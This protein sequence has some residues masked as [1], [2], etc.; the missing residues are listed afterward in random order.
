M[1]QKMRNI[2]PEDLRKESN[3]EP[4]IE[5]NSFDNNKMKTRGTI[6][7]IIKE[8]GFGFIKYDDDKEIFFHFNEVNDKNLISLGANV[9]FEIGI[10][11]R[12]NKSEAKKVT[13]INIESK[14]GMNEPQNNSNNIT[15]I[16]LYPKDTYDIIKNFKSENFSL[17]YNKFIHCEIE[18]GKKIKFSIK[19]KEKDI[20]HFVFSKVSLENILNVQEKAVKSLFGETN[21]KTLKLEIDWRLIVGLGTESVY[22]T[23]MTLHPIYGI[24]YIPGQSIKGIVRSW[25]INEYFNSKEEN[26]LINSEAFCKIFGCPKEIKTEEIIKKTFLK[27]DYQGSMIF[28]DAFPLD[29]KSENLKMDIMNPHYAPYYSE[30]HPPADYYNP[31]PI[32]FMTLE[33]TSFK[34]FIGVKNGKNEVINEK[35]FGNDNLLNITFRFLKEAL[36]NQGIG[37]KTAVGYGFFKE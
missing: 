37:A 26:A 15:P 3:L 16:D 30:G 5:N 18:N 7:N 11:T 25:I 10:N 20:T 28:F 22:E 6:K 13:V 35:E 23:S 9:E 2:S 34:F 12:N 4:N 1:A 14:I 27:K 24:P 36:I 19:D 33:N 32:P 8:K 17:I 29:L 31:T 21:F